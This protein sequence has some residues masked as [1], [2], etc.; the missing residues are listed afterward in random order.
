MLCLIYD[1][2]DGG[3][4]LIQGI[5]HITS[6]GAFMVDNFEE[7]IY[8]SER[9]Y[10]F[11]NMPLY[12]FIAAKLFK[13]SIIEDGKIRFKEKIHFHEDNIFMLEYLAAVCR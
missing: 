13:R 4:L 3:A 9:L 11:F 12:G 2:R 5:N 7:F 6:V 8:E 10:E 1:K